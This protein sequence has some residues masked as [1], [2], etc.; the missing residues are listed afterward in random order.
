MKP[1]VADGVCR[2]KSFRWPTSSLMGFAKHTSL[3]F[4]ARAYFPITCPKREPQSS[5]LNISSDWNNT[6]NEWCYSGK[7]NVPLGNIPMP[8]QWVQEFAMMIP[9]YRRPQYCSIYENR[10]AVVSRSILAEARFGM[11]TGFKIGVS[12]LEPP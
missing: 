6:G 4:I 11:T 1:L 12:M 8:L 3:A 10:W 9:Q 5:S 7:Y 2:F